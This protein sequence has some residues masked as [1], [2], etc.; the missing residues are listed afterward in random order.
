MA[1]IAR[2]LGKTADADR[3][4]ARAKGVYAAYQ[5]AFFDKQRRVYVDGEGTDHA[6]QHAN[7]AALAFGLVPRDYR[8][9]VVAFCA[10][11][12]VRHLQQIPVVE[13]VDHGVH[14]PE[15]EPVALMRRPVDDVRGANGVRERIA[16]TL[17]SKSSAV[18]PNELD[19]CWLGFVKSSLSPHEEK[20]QRPI[21]RASEYLYSFILLFLILY[22]MCKI[23]M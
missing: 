7:A 6:S 18:S 1:D 15:H 22:I 21:M 5:R 12:D 9:D 4:A 16:Q 11:R 10:S 13:R 19:V 14:V 3:F 8:R 2:A 17:S 23:R 20:V